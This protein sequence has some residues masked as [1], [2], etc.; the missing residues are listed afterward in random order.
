MPAKQQM[1]VSV[2]STFPSLTASG[3]WAVKT[4]AIHRNTMVA[5]SIHDGTNLKT[6]VRIINLSEKPRIFRK[7]DLITEAELVEICETEESNCDIERD[8]SEEI[9]LQPDSGYLSNSD[10]ESFDSRIKQ[11]LELKQTKD[12]TNHLEAM[13]NNN[14]ASLS[15]RDEKKL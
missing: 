14:G 15:E 5:S 1:H 6:I 4:K 12:D 11:L 13:F 7:G 3:I 10:E 2:V 8:F 9:K